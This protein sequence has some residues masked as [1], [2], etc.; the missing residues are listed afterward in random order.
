MD[1]HKGNDSDRV[2]KTVWRWRVGVATQEAAIAAKQR[3][4]GVWQAALG[5]AV[6]LLMYLLSLRTAAVLVVAVSLVILSVALLSPRSGF[7]VLERAME[8]FGRFIGDIVAFLV[9]TPL[10][11][12]F[13]TPFHWL[14][15]RGSRDA[16]GRHLDPRSATYW[17]D[18]SPAAGDLKQYEKM[19]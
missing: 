13:F 18:R 19:F 2:S 15:R 4:K 5:L 7:A 17:I 1:V 10:Y 6:G 9:L 3:W 14:F 11:Y 8:R 16:M 12:L